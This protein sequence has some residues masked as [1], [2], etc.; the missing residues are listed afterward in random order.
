MSNRET[1][2]IGK[3]AILLFIASIVL[4]VCF[5]AGCKTLHDAVYGN[6]CEYGGQIHAP[7]ENDGYREELVRMAESIGI[8]T[9]G[10]NASDLSS[11]IGYKLDCGVDVPNA[12]GIE[13]FEKMAKDLNPKEEESMRAYHR[14]ISDLQGKRVIIIEPEGK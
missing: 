5:L 14:F 1:S 12:L 7:S 2:A 6:P 8:K 9:A 3:L 10:K 11:D 13:E 4:N